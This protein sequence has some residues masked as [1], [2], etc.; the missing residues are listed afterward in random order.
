M[1]R[2]LVVLELDRMV[3]GREGVLL[4]GSKPDCSVI[5][6]VARLR[7]LTPDPW[8]NSIETGRLKRGCVDRR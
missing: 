2:S 4:P 3:W 6:F 5:P 7:T 1:D 8:D